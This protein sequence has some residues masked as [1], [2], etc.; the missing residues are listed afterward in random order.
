MKAHR[1]ILRKFTDW[2]CESSQIVKAHT[3]IVN[4]H[5]LRLWKL[6]DWLKV[7]RLRLWNFTDWDCEISQTATV[8]CA[9]CSGN[10]LLC[11]SV[12]ESHVTV[13]ESVGKLYENAGEWVKL[14]WIVMSQYI[15][16]TWTPMY[17]KC[18]VSVSWVSPEYFVSVIPSAYTSLDGKIG[19]S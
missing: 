12:D 17:Y 7:H 13:C 5:R 1:L 4:A 15:E 10:F 16:F 8:K 14:M 11:K 6:T 19:S 18:I 3:G 2:D 9:V